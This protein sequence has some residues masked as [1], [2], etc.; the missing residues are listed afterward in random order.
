[1]PTIEPRRLSDGT[2][3]YR[4]RVRLGRGRT[5]AAT[6]KRKTDAIRWAQQTEADLRRAKYFKHE[7]TQKVTLDEAI[8]RYEREILPRKPRTAKFQRTQLKW[9]R[10]ELGDVRLAELT[11]SMISEARAKLMATPGATKRGRGPSTAN[12]YLAVLSH[13]LSTAIREWELL[14]INPT[15]K[16]ANLREPRGREVFLSDDEAQQLLDECRRVDERLYLVTLLAMSTGMRRMEILSLRRWQVDL[17]RKTIYLDDTK[18]GERRG[19]ALAG[20]AYLAL[21]DWLQAVEDRQAL[22]FPGSS[23]SKHYEPRSKW[24]KVRLSTSLKGVR[25]HDMRHTAASF[26]LK[27][28]ASLPETGAILGHKSPI[29]TKRYAHFAQTHLHD[30]VAK[31]NERFAR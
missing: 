21:A 27:D 25:L 12:R 14:E 30:V 24:E 6:F 4:A 3:S 1:M 31:M 16:L 13:L 11:T 9:W 15:S 7:A 28:G 2:T 19:V 18:N 26:L 10:K 17:D 20:P 29:T 23:A 8:S 5:A 22:V